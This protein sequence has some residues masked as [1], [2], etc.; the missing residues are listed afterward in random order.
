VFVIFRQRKISPDWLEYDRERL[1]ELLPIIGK[2]VAIKKR[3]SKNADII[4]LSSKINDESSRGFITLMPDSR[5]V[6]TNRLARSI[7][8]KKELIKLRGDKVEICDK[9]LK[10]E[11][12]QQL[13]QIQKSSERELSAYSWYRNIGKLPE[14]GDLLLTMRAFCPDSWR[15]ESSAHNRTIV[16]T[17]EKMQRQT[18]PNEAQLCEFFNL[19]KA[20]ARLVKQLTRSS[21][22]EDAANALNI[23]VNTARSHL[24]AI[25]ERVGVSD[26]AQLLQRVG[27]TIAGRGIG[28]E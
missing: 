6:A 13:A 20:Q 18:T 21:G 9:Q 26:K 14:S 8:D 25:Y 22:V 28:N 5:V 4:E 23:S 7:L 27:S 10:I 15:R 1:R 24:R 17:L 16:I 19:T 12:E 11:F 2:S 3:L